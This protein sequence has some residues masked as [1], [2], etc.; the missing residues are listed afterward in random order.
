MLCSSSEISCIYL[1]HSSSNETA[2]LTLTVR[3]R[4]AIVHTLHPTS[5]HRCCQLWL[6]AVPVAA[7]AAARVQHRLLPG[8][9][10]ARRVERVV[11]VQVRGQ[12]SDHDPRFLTDFFARFFSGSP[13]LAY[14]FQTA[15][16]CSHAPFE[17]SISSMHIT[18]FPLFTCFLSFSSV[19][20]FVSRYLVYPSPLFFP[21]L[22]LFSSPTNK[23]HGVRRR[24]PDAHARRQDCATVRRPALRHTV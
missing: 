15:L 21:R 4:S 16:F 14:P 7:H 20:A 19:S 2:T 22:P 24:A 17:I 23:Q 10:R 11:R 1:S 13:A 5:F 3:R 8:R 18:L 9:L 6:R 12:Q